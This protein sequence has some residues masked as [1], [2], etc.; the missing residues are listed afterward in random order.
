[1]HYTWQ[2]IGGR[3]D[4]STNNEIRVADNILAGRRKIFRD[5]NGGKPTLPLYSLCPTKKWI[6]R[7]TDCPTKKWISL[8]LIPTFVK[9]YGF[10][11][12]SRKLSPIRS[13]Q[14]HNTAY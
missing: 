11:M 13:R 12:V 7:R 6:S 2:R 8:V 14:K 3:L 9:N 10:A 4:D 1:M 5:E